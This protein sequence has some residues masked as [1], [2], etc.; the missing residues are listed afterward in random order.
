MV[1][2]SDEVRFQGEEDGDFGTKFS[3]RNT[4]LHVDYHDVDLELI[5][6]GRANSDTTISPVLSPRLSAA[7]SPAASRC[8]SP[9]SRA[10]SRGAKTFYDGFL[11]SLE[12]DEYGQPNDECSNH[13]GFDLEVSD[14]DSST[15][16]SNYSEC[17]GSTASN[18]MP[19]QPAPMQ[20]APMQPSPMQG[21]LVQGMIPLPFNQAAMG[22][23]FVIPTFINLMPSI[24]Q[25]FQG[26]VGN[27]PHSQKNQ[28]QSTE[29]IKEANN[30]LSVDEANENE[31]TTVMIRNVPSDFTRY[32][33]E[34]TLN[35]NGFHTEYNFAYVPISFKSDKTSFG[36]ALVNFR[37]NQSAQRFLSEFEGYDGW[38]IGNNVDDTI[39]EVGFS[40]MQGLQANIERYRN[41]PLMHKSVP[42]ICRPAVYYA[43]NLVPFPSPDKKIQAPNAVQKGRAAHY[44]SRRAL[45]AQQQYANGSW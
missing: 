22:Q 41:S 9:R 14:M 33:L 32:R 45:K 7:L 26:N 8:A 5:T 40:K 38:N 24:Q 19:M 12:K 16:T 43:G 35:Q 31:Q 37:N 34:E 30:L 42:D 44:K 27:V 1:R 28:C 2:F 15:S 17:G 36:Y 6:R 21:L 3:I 29:T 13:D 25:S 18:S 11:S 23:H 10:G 20:P 4:F 39:A